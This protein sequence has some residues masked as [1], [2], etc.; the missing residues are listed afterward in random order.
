MNHMSDLKSGKAYL[1]NALDLVV[2]IIP[3]EVLLG[4][5]V[6]E[7]AIALAFPNIER[8]TVS[9]VDESVEVRLQLASYVRRKRLAR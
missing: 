6:R 2:Q 4:T 8:L 3:F 7:D 1:P 9:R 5:D